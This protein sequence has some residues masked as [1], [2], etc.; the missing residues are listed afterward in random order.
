MTQKNPD[1]GS[2]YLPVDSIAS[3]LEPF[4]VDRPV[5]LAGRL[6]AR[7]IM[8]KSSFCD[9]KDENGRVQLYGK[10]DDLGDETFDRFCSVSLGDIIGIEG[11][12][13]LSKMFTLEK[14]LELEEK[15]KSG[16]VAR[17]LKRDLRP[18]ESVLS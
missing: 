18:R 17:L 16:L 13:F 12:L 7:R 3:I 11:K 2:R 14:R 8:G 15:L 4:Q 5:R 9:L 6:M 10:K 1:Y